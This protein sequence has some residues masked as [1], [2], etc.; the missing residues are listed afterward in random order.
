VLVEPPVPVIA[1]EDVLELEELPPAP[2]L[3]EVSSLH[4]V[5]ANTPPRTP[6]TAK[7]R[8]VLMLAPPS[9]YTA[10]SR[11]RSPPFAVAAPPHPSDS[12]PA[13]HTVRLSWTD[14]LLNRT[15]E[16]IRLQ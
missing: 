14:D 15:D 6:Y 4:P 12:E 13:P 10:K 5:M 9:M 1:V 2:P 7:E 3:P 16:I 8:T 11:G